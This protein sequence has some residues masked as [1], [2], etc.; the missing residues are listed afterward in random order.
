QDGGQTRGYQFTV[1]SGISSVE[2]HLDNRVGN[3]VLV[4]RNGDQFPDPGATFP[5][6]PAEI[7]GNE[8]GYTIG[9]ILT[10]AGAGPSLVTLANP[11]AG[12]YSLVVKA[13]STAQ[14]IFPA[15]SYTVRV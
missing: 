13:R 6:G 5:G 9:Q 4:V 10:N 14:G 12:N 7:Y 3:P 2:V 1:P 15:A 8:G 11:P